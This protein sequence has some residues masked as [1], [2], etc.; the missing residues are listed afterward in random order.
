MHKDVSVK[1]FPE[2]SNK[3]SDYTPEITYICVKSDLKG[4]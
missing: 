3:L 1:E 4:K 2:T